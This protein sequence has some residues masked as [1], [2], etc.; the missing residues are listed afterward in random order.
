MQQAIHTNLEQTG[1]CPAGDTVSN[2][3]FI[4]ICRC[5]GGHSGLI[6]RCIHTRQ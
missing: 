1:I 4:R 3:V 2:G 5:H 6:F